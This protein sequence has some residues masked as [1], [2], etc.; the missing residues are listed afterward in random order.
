MARTQG[1]FQ[2]IRSQT[3]KLKNEVNE[4]RDFNKM[5]LKRS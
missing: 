2:K 3:R 1:D 5:A 4:L